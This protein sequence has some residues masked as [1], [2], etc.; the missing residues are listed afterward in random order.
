LAVVVVVVVVVVSSRDRHGDH[1]A[2]EG[3]NNERPEQLHDERF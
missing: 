1:E 3:E 2:S